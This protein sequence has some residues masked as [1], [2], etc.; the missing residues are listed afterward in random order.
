MCSDKAFPLFATDHQKIVKKNDKRSHDNIQ[1]TT[2]KTNDWSMRTPLKQD[3]CRLS[4]KVR[5]ICPYP[6]WLHSCFFLAVRIDQSLVVCVVFC[7]SL[8]VLVLL[9][10]VLSVILPFTVSNCYF[11]QTLL[12]V[13]TH[14]PD[15]LN[16]SY[17][18]R[19]PTFILF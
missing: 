1:H 16:Y 3:E 12:K 6:S 19:Q 5:V 14:I 15:E 9:T 10:I 4:G 2:Q 8:F 11:L 7:R 17:L 13:L 18:S